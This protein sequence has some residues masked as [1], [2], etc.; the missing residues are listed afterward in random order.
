MRQ[1]I[2]IGKSRNADG[3]QDL[4]SYFWV[5]ARCCIE[6][7]SR[8]L[9]ASEPAVS[10][11][12]LSIN[13]SVLSLSQRTSSWNIFQ[14]GC[15]GDAYTLSKQHNAKHDGSKLK[16]HYHFLV[17]NCVAFNHVFLRTFPLLK[18]RHISCSKL[19]QWYVVVEQIIN[20]LKRLAS[21]FWYAKVCKDE[22]EERKA[23]KNE[24]DF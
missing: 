23:A 9:E 10:A 14:L 12:L 3:A 7:C 4:E 18:C 11:P 15:C 1:R 2:K 19:P 17:N 21:A 20:L 13:M 6:S 24:A 22:A 16:L 5:S 8:C